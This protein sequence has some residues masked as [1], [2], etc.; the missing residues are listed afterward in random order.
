MQVGVTLLKQAYDVMRLSGE[1]LLSN[2]STLVFSAVTL[3]SPSSRIFSN[4]FAALV[5]QDFLWKHLHC[6]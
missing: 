5:K 4:S 2:C 1:N 6:N 3:K